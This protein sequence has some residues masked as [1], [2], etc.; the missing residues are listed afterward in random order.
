MLQ[1]L[2]FSDIF[3]MKD[4]DDLLKESEKMIKFKHLH[5][6]NLIGVCIDSGKAPFIIM[7]YMA[8]GSLLTYL[9][10]ERPKLTIAQGAEEITVI[11]P[12]VVNKAIDI[13]FLKIADAK[14]KL[15]SICLQIAKGMC[16]LAEQKFVH[17]DLAARNCM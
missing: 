17:R 15:L 1:Y 12:F 16:Y 13:I 14:R 9:K 2:A 5:V 10:K 8:N 11:Q 7:P 6:L 4:I 3:S